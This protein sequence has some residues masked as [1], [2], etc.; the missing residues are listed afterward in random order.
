VR[1]LVFTEQSDTYN[2]CEKI[3]R[4]R[5]PGNHTSKSHTTELLS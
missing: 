3:L 5:I 2:R 1:E 4:L